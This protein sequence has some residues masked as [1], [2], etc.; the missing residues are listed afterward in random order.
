MS[1]TTITPAAAAGRLLLA[2]LT[3]TEKLLLDIRAKGTPITVGGVACVIS[4]RHSRLDY[5]R[6]HRYS[7]G[8]EISLPWGSHTTE[9]RAVAD[10][11]AFVA[12]LAEPPTRDYINHDECRWRGTH[13]APVHVCPAC[14]PKR[15]HESEPCPHCNHSITVCAPCA[16]HAADVVPAAEVDQAR[17][18]GSRRGDHRTGILDRK[19]R[20]CGGGYCVAPELIAV[21]GGALATGY[22]TLYAYSARDGAKFGSGTHHSR[23]ATRAKAQAKLAAYLKAQ[24]KRYAAQARKGRL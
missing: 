3:W 24:A 19:G 14:E 9:A 23:H 18:A 8:A 4:N 7:D 13:P 10:A 12:S 22:W 20:D 2:P 5:Y 17:E 15:A 11:E 16:E 1:T 21:P 6:I